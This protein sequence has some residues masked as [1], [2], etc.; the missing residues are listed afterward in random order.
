M[1]PANVTSGSWIKYNILFFIEHF[2]GQKIYNKIFGGIEKKLYEKIDAEVTSKGRLP[3]LKAIDLKEGEY[4]DPFTDP[5]L[6]IIFR[7]AAKNW[8][9]TKN[10]DFDFFAKNYGDIEVTLINNAGLVKDSEQNNNVVTFKEYIDLLK[11][12]RKEYLKFSRVLEDKSE[13]ISDMDHKWLRKFRTKNARNDLFYFFMGGKGTITPLHDGFAHTVFIQLKGSKKWTFYKT[14]DRL[15]VGSRPRRYN[16]FYSDVDLGDEKN[17]LAK[18]AQPFEVI[19]NEGDVLFFPS[20]IW[21]QVEN[22]T[23]SIGVA[24]KFADL[25]GG[26]KSSKMLTLCMLLATKP[27]IFYSLIPALGDT[28]NYKKKEKLEKKFENLD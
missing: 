6:P 4:T 23:D 12:G 19:I 2:L 13:L 16:Y 24:Y 15:F 18:H 25:Q 10:W 5:Y 11:Q 27:P 20:L 9:A 28:Y 7:G 21:H 26:W 3:E 1:R 17:I 22:V 14:S 8:N